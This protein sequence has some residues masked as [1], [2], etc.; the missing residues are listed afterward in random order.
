MFFDMQK[1]RVF[2][3]RPA[4]NFFFKKKKVF[5]FVRLTRKP[6]TEKNTC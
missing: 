2:N 4:A 3:K 1:Y 6:F 5:Y